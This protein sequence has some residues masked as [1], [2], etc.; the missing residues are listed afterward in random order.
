MHQQAF[1]LRIAS[2]LAEC[3]AQYRQILGEE[4]GLEVYGR[5]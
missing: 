5:G 4:L 3:P 1:F 2:K